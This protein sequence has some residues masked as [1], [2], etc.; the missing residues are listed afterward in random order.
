MMLIFSIILLKNA[1]I[2]GLVSLLLIV[3]LNRLQDAI[4]TDFGI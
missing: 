4:V 1:Y 2:M 3:F